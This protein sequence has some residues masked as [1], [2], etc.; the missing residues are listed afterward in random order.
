ML[1]LVTLTINKKWF[2]TK[3]L[4]VCFGWEF[5][6]HFPS[7][8]SLFVMLDSQFFTVNFIDKKIIC[9]FLKSK[10]QIWFFFIEAIFLLDWLDLTIPISMQISA[11]K[12]LGSDPPAEPPLLSRMNNEQQG[13]PGFQTRMNLKKKNR[14]EC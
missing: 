13:P 11:L 10:F 12:V 14:L 5:C 2:Q 3:I 8:I 1:S 6:S 9:Y 4:N 7:G